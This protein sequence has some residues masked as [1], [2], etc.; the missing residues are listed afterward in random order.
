M[1]GDADVSSPGKIRKFG[2]ALLLDVTPL[3]ARDLLRRW[4]WKSMG[5]HDAPWMIDGFDHHGNGD[6]MD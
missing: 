4:K 5:L 2:S 3:R 1:F 6:D